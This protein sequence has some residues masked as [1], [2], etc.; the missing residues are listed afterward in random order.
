LALASIGLGLC[1]LA[2]AQTLHSITISWSYTQG[3]DL[4]AG[5]NVY[6][7][8]TNGGPYTQINPTILPL[9]TLSFAD[10]VNVGGVKY[11]YVVRAVDAE[12]KLSPDSVQVSA[13]SDAA[14]A[15]PLAPTGITAVA[16]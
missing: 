8:T 7:S 6:R 4:A 15:A 3:T 13:V 16:K 14:S 5:F 2:E 10:T 1:A 11:Y 12:G 9:T